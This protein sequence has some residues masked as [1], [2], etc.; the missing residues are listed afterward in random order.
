VITFR[1]HSDTAIATNALVQVTPARIRGS[2]G[3]GG[4]GG[5][6]GASNDKN[7]MRSRARF[8]L[9]E[10]VSEGPIAGLVNG[11]QSIYFDQTPLKNADGT[12]NFKEVVW[13]DHKGTADEGYFN[14][15][16]AV[17]TPVSVETQVR[18][19]VGDVQRTI[20]DENA[21]AVRVIMRVP[22]LVKQ[23]DK[24]GLKGTN[25]SYAIDVRAFNGSWT[26]A[27][28]NEL[29]KE[30]ALSPFQMDHRIDLPQDGSP[31]DIRVRRITDD[32]TD[33][34]LQNDLFWEGYVVLVEGKFTYPFTAAFAMEGNAEEMGSN[35]PPRS[36]HIR[37][38]LVHV[39]SNYNPLTRV[40]TGVWD[41]S[42]KIAWTN[43]PA[44]IFY[45]LIVNDR[46]GLGEFITPEIVDKWS[47]YTIAQYCDQ[48]VKSG[49][50]NGDTGADI[51]EPRFTY[52]GVINTK[53]EA[54]FVLQTITKAWRGMAYWA[55]GQV[56]AAADMPADPVRL[57][58]P[59]NVIGGDFEY[60]GTALKARHSVVMVKWN[61]P[62]DFYRP[63]TEVVID[64]KLLHKN[65]WREKTVQL[66][67]C[68][69]RG[70]AHRFGKWV[71]DSEQN[72]TDTLTYS[73]SWDHAEVRPGEIVAVSDP[74]KAQIRA[75]GRIVSHHGLQLELDSDFE[76]NE[77]ETYQLMLTLPSGEIETKPILAFLDDR[78]VRVSSAFSNEA[79]PDAM[80]TIKGSDIAPRL[81]RVLNVEESEP[82]IFKITA[83]FH[84][85]S[86]YAR[87]EEGIVFT[88]LP[89]DRPSK[90][91]SPP[92]NL[93]VKETGFI[94]N[95]KEYH[96][97]TLSWTAPQNQLVRGFIV[98]VDTPE[99]G[100]F[101]LGSTDAAF[102]ET[103]NTTSGTYKFY[104]QTIGYTGA[105]SEAA[106]IEF[107]AVGAEG[108][109]RPTVTNLELVDRP[110]SLEFTGRDLKFRWKNNFALTKDGPLDSES[111]PHY[112]F[113]SVKL[114]HGGTGELLRTERVVGSGYVY[115]IGSN[116]ADCARL[117]HATPTRVVRVDVTVSD[118][119]GRTSDAVSRVFSNP[120]PAPVVPSYNVV[121]STIFFSYEIPADPDLAGVLIWRELNPEIDV[122]TMLPFY[123]GLDNMLTIPGEPETVYFFKM[124]AYD[125][126]GKEGLNY[127]P[128]FFITTLSDGA[129]SE[130]PATPTGLDVTSEI[131][132]DGR[133]RV[134]AIWNANTE[135]DLAGY[136]LEIKQAS[137]NFV[138]YPTANNVFEFDSLPGL[139][140]SFRLRA[141][142]KNANASPTTNVLIHTVAKDIVPPA[143]P[144]ALTISTGLTAFW[145]SWINPAD[146]DLDHIEIL[147]GVTNVSADATV[148][149]TSA[150]T[151]FARTGLESN[152]Q[153]FYWVRAVDTS[154]NTS[155]L[156]LIAQGTTATLPDA[157]RISISG[158]VL[159]PNSPSANKVAWGAFSITYGVPGGVPTTKSIEA[160][161]VTWTVGSLYLY[162]VEGET[163]L[164]ST[165]DVATIF[166][167]SGHPIGVYRGGTD[168]QLTDGKTMID[169]NNVITG[170]IGA[171]QLVVNDAIITNSLQL[172]D[173]VIT[174]AKIE[175]LSAD[176]L[177]ADTTISNTIIVGGGDTLATIR[178]R[179]ADPASRVNEG[180]TLIEPGKILIAGETSLES[181]RAG[182]DLTE[183]NGG[184]VAANT[185]KANSAV[186][187]M[188][189]IT[190][191]GITFEHNSPSANRVSWT[192]GTI[193][194]TDDA[195]ASVTRAITASN[196]LWSAGTL[197]LYWVKGATTISTST[198]FA[199]ANDDNNVVL[200][201]YKGGIFLFAS[202]G[203]TVIDGGQ[204]K[205]QS[206]TANQMTV[207]SVTAQTIS[208][209]SLAAISANLGAVTAGS[210]NINNRFIVDSA[211]NLTVRSATTGARLEITSTYILMVDAT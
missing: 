86:K 91:V 90:L 155:A 28:T 107:E 188:R 163:I 102:F 113:N 16:S 21:D 54:F 98:S 202:Y 34:K 141:R 150:G 84:D 66:Q 165:A 149:G 131:G 158:L 191:D 26:T 96:S 43:N 152:A 173:A 89:Y 99:D 161:N 67:G 7:T 80:W 181:W 106:T 136:D 30:K 207:G 78:T 24:G 62:D 162:Y 120:V 36:Y 137:G 57:V 204:I 147:E 110:E 46:Y 101:S 40:Y 97:L 12:Y 201:C 209:T 45:D 82:N 18:K 142:D 48:Q 169:G 129:D 59:A 122:D 164:R 114:Y 182:A 105:I 127:G 175:N 42:F 79:Q 100:S 92:T 160:S 177:T 41:G 103:P 8:R 1:S 190:I 31:W 112:V 157:K 32:S 126:F 37:G 172:K 70:L 145:L 68:T 171:Q 170:T 186:I 180:A 49:F 93:L 14:G 146:L 196:A 29:N 71:I 4:K 108:Y 208:V 109:A 176:K 13:K 148:I 111:S 138:S 121:G 115:D 20:V 124:A 88:P 87:V 132:I 35:I 179:A 194:Y 168:I 39:P 189:G 94:T 198:D 195:G 76:W 210:L 58:S 51:Y 187:G 15:H 184:S 56:F 50:R 166:T 104:V 22:S 174:S 156:S 65:G 83:L 23:D 38:L 52:N 151:S 135:E 128:E 47:L 116:R 178:D 27:V 2:G 154:G 206:I 60:A 133:A 199:T 53:D 69:T 203:R 167:Q 197:Y 5:G 3:G 9:I 183:I 185:L 119:F 25:L 75:S 73:A 130:P 19:S 153:R 72:E 200:G 81:Y 17:E 63:D 211:G 123:D 117:G 140:Y 144:T 64:S 192:A 44:W 33:D 74:R 159:T 205:T 55:M 85:P 139:V 10:A 77:G 95:G 143:A 11:E 61:N 125:S 134:T 6:S 118:V 193:A